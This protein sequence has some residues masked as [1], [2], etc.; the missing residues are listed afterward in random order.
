MEL[1]TFDYNIVF[2]KRKNPLMILS[3]MIR[4][5]GK[6]PYSHCGVL[7]KVGSEYF[8]YES[9]MPRSKC[10]P[11]KE[12]MDMYHVV[13]VNRLTPMVDNYSCLEFLNE[14][15]NIRYSF[16]QLILLGL[17]FITLG[18]IKPLLTNGQQRLVCSEYCARFIT[19]ACKRDFHKPFDSITLSDVDKMSDTTSLPFY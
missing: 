11:Y 1:E 7:V 18:L 15:L 17:S 12:W 8:V 19:F 2:G 10:T 13:K 3:W 16:K 14:M 5:I 9:T 4:F 6:T